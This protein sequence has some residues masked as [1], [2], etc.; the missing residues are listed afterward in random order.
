MLRIGTRKSPLALVQARQVAERLGVPHEI[1]AMTTSGDQLSD[2]PLSEEGGKGL[3]TKELEEALLDG[4]IDIAVHSMKDVA[5]LLPSGLHIPCVLPREDVRDVLICEKAT[6]I[7]DLPHGASFG[8]SSLRR[9]A[10]VLH[11]R[12][13]LQIVPLR[14]NVGTRLAKIAQGQAVATMLARAGINRLGLS[15]IPAHDIPVAE[16]LPAVAQGTIG[17]ECVIANEKIHAMLMA[18]NCAATMAAITCERAFLRV[19]DG[20]CRTPIAGYARSEQGML[21]FDGLIAS[22]DGTD[23]RRTSISGLMSDAEAL[24]SQAG[25]KLRVG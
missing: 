20:S 6:C 14:G 23:I 5:T 19:L 16:C 24:G 7:A 13:D 11:M 10:Q 17:I 22:P 9:A 8:T 25:E 1:V 12:P 21:Y 15:G 2:R 3:F 4:R 18:L